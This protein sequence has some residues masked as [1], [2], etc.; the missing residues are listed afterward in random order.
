MRN[1]NCNYSILYLFNFRGHSRLFIWSIFLCYN[2]FD[3][4]VSEGDPVK[5][6]YNFFTRLYS[7]HTWGVSEV[8]QN[9]SLIS[10]Q[11]VA[12]YKQ[13]S[14]FAKID[15]ILSKSI[16]FYQKHGII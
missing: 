14:Y 6:N 13:L 3:P 9:I 4:H 10:L 8:S 7:L 5:C 16:V 11:K 1:I 2:S 12:L 15:I